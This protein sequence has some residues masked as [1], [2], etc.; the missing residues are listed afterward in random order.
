M[1]A[2]PVEVDMCTFLAV[3][4]HGLLHI[5]I[6]ILTGCRMYTAV[7]G[8]VDILLGQ[9]VRQIDWIQLSDGIFIEFG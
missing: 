8:H 3:A 9:A 4:V 6:Q 1:N 5:C 2:Q 7:Y